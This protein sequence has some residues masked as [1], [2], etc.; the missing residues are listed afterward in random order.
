MGHWSLILRGPP[1]SIILTLRRK[2]NP[3]PTWCAQIRSTPPSRESRKWE[4]WGSKNKVQGSWDTGERGSH[5]VSEVPR[6]RLG[7]VCSLCGHPKWE[8]QHRTVGTADC[9]A[10]RVRGKPASSTQQMAQP[11]LTPCSYYAGESWDTQGFPCLPEASAGS[12]S[13]Q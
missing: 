4:I 8:A 11:S 9:R 12:L 10:H 5:T 1:P 6:S 2:S 3:I 7:W 13:K